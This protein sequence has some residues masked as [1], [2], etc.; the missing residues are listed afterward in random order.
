MK[1]NVVNSF[2][3]SITYFDTILY[4]SLCMGSI[5]LAH[6]TLLPKEGERVWWKLYQVNVPVLLKCSLSSSGGI[7]FAESTHTMRAMRGHKQHNSAAGAQVV[8][9]AWFGIQTVDHKNVTVDQ[10]VLRPNTATQYK[11]IL[12]LSPELL[13]PLWVGESGAWD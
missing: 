4:C 12:Q 1:M 11:C 13:L 9:V 7:V 6:Q 2:T 10:N 5:S 8:H 3:K